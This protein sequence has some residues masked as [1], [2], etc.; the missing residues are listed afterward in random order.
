[1]AKRLVQTDRV[2]A[3]AAYAALLVLVAGCAD[4]ARVVLFEER[5]GNNALTQATIPRP[6]PPPVRPPIPA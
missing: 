2:L 6:K 4:P 1:M 3:G 5:Y